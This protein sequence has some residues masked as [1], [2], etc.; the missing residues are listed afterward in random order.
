L[1]RGF[2]DWSLWYS[3]ERKPVLVFTPMQCFGF[4][5]DVQL[6]FGKSNCKNGVFKFPV[7]QCEKRI[8]V[9]DR[10]GIFATHRNTR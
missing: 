3:V 6:T 5:F 10:E 9:D 4:G 7:D 2:S 1:I 8:I